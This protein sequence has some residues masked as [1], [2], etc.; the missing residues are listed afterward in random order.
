MRAFISAI[1]Y[2]AA[3]VLAVCLGLFLFKLSVVYINIPLS[4]ALLGSF[5]DLQSA[6]IR[7]DMSAVVLGTFWMFALVC[8]SAVGYCTMLVGWLPL[9]AL[10]RFKLRFLRRR[11]LRL[12]PQADLFRVKAHSPVPMGRFITDQKRVSAAHKV[13]EDFQ[14]REGREN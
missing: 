1:C 7:D 8:V 6:I 3:I 4:G 12:Q 2:V 9:Y 11:Q 5:M 10:Y 13:S 14:E